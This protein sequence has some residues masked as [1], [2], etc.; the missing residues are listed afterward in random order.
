MKLVE[1]GVEMYAGNSREMPLL[2]QTLY[3][4]AWSTLGETSEI[5]VTLL[6]FLMIVVPALMASCFWVVKEVAGPSHDWSDSSCFLGLQ[7]EISRGGTFVR[8]AVHF[9]FCSSIE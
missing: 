9:G 1:P 5:G 6:R 8:T 4:L 2:A 7:G 3:A